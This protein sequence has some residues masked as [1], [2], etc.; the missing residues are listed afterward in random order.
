MSDSPATYS[1]SAN[2]RIPTFREVHW[3]H[4]APRF[5][6]MGLPTQ[7]WICPGSVDWRL[8]REVYS[9][10]REGFHSVQCNCSHYYLLLF[11]THN[12]MRAQTGSCQTMGWDWLH[13]LWFNISLSTA[14]PV[15][16][17]SECN[18]SL[19]RSPNHHFLQTHHPWKLW[20][21]ELFSG[22]ILRWSLTNTP[23]PLLSS[24]PDNFL[25]KTETLSGGS[26][27][28]PNPLW[29]KETKFLYPPYKHRQRLMFASRFT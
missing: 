16:L 24:M 28:Y 15:A 2:R 12:K 27:I 26:D 8:W 18:W 20:R 25:Q 9:S 22:L 21:R 1:H 23:S 11:P 17:S 10:V 3:V 14:I 19:C 5:G 13:V 7:H 4:S 29:G 6:A